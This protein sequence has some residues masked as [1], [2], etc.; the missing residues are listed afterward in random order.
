MPGRTAFARVCEPAAAAASFVRVGPRAERASRRNVP[1]DAGQSFPAR[2]RLTRASDFQQVFK[3]NF[4]RSDNCIT[5]L[6]G[7]KPG[8]WPR[9]GFAIARKQIPRAVKR[10]ALK[11]LF[12]ES[13]RINRHRLPARDMVIMV[14]REI[15]SSSPA[16]IRSRLERHWNG[17]I[18]QCEKS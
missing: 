6:V 1:V 15:L 16:E 14:R 18:E 5:I 8:S 2:L 17:I 9:I 12:R 13:F 11:R 7:K 4:R 10:N 3:N